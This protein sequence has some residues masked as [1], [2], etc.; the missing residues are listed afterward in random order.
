[1]VNPMKHLTMP[2]TPLLRDPQDVRIS[3]LPVNDEIAI[4]GIPWDWAITGRPGAR[5]A[6]SLIRRTMYNYR[7]FIPGVGRLKWRP[8]DLGDVKIVPG[9]FHTTAIRII[10]TVNNIAEAYK[11][12]LVLG[13]DHSITEWV[14]KPFLSRGSLGLLLLDAHYDMRSTSEG[15]TSGAWLWNLYKE[16]NEKIKAGIIGIAPYA[17]PPYLEER[18]DKA[19]FRVVPSMIAERN[20]Q[21]WLD[22]IKWLESLQLDTYYISIDIDHLDQ[23]YAPGV[24]APSP[25]GLSPYTSIEI[26]EE[27]VKRLC[28][29]GIDIVEIVPSLDVAGITVR[30]GGLLALYTLHVYERECLNG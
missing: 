28:P 6:P 10:E 26:L 20:R 8:R 7:P 4:V 11:L 14:L 3:D 1:M 22:V 29:R 21:A 15:Y 18:A 16:F 19:G 12:L 24:N 27:A 9:D 17:N 13:G 2:G 30:I 5:E 25:L 23:S